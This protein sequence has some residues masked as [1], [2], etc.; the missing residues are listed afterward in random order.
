[1]RDVAAEH[2][3]PRFRSLADQDVETKTGPL[4]LVTIADREAE[5]ALTRR[6]PDLVPGSVVVG[7]EAVCADPTIVARLAEDAPVW[8]LDP[9]DGTRNFVNGENLFGVMVAL[10]ERQETICGWIFTPIDDIMLTV[11]RGAGAR[12]NG[13]APHPRTAVSFA[14][15]IGDFTPR[16]FVEPGTVTVDGGGW[17]GGTHRRKSLLPPTPISIRCVVRWTLISPTSS[18]LGIMPPAHSP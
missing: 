2:V 11:E 16:Y 7:E 8:V 12:V 9:V 15:A 1:M 3:M 17:Q 10:V 13:Q 5:A 18:R 6:L 14:D 4:D